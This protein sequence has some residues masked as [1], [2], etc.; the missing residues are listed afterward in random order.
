MSVAIHEA[1]H[2]VMAWLMGSTPYLASVIRDG[3]SAGRV[4]F[5]KTPSPSTNRKNASEAQDMLG[6]CFNV[7]VDVPAPQQ[8]RRV[9]ELR[10]RAAMMALAGQLAVEQQERHYGFQVRRDV[11]RYL[12]HARGDLISAI[13]ALSVTMHGDF[14]PYFNR[15]E[16]RARRCLAH[17]MIHRATIALAEELALR[18]T[19]NR[20]QIKQIIHEVIHAPQNREGAYR[21]KIRQCVNF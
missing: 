10:E 21:R 15:V 5:G 9:H 13:A 1:G 11:W 16:E 3:E 2:A 6:E 4:Q 12:P 8:T 20:D 18:G 17:P 7:L 19:L 14:E